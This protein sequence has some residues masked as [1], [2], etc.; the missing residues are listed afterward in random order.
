MDPGPRVLAVCGLAFEAAIAAGPGVVTVC[1]PGPARIEAW[2]D[3]RL[4]ARL[5]A[6][7]DAQLGDPLGDPRSR[8]DDA[9]GASGRAPWSGIISFGC[10]GALDPGLAPGSCVVA[11]SVL[12]GGELVA[13]DPVWTRALLHRLPCARP[14]RLAGLD[15]P[16]RSSADKARLWR[17]SGACAVDMESQA[18]ARAA[19]RL[20]LPFAVL[21][22]VLDPA[23]REIPACALAGMRADGTRALLPLLGGLA[24]DPR[25]LAPLCA[26]ARDAWQARRSLRQAR[27]R[28]GRALALPVPH[29]SAAAPGLPPR[30]DAGGSSD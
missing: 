7:L 21:R 18:A 25:Q 12:C 24:R 8:L 30:S 5:D 26:L 16:L 14:G 20:G 28:L 15:A 11:S 22:V 2:L 29:A 9:P 6:Q 17:E 10:A 4:D 23:W 19:R 13:S 3:A 27:A 1:G